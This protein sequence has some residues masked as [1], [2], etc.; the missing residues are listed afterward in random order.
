V[1]LMIF[2]QLQTTLINKYRLQDLKKGAAPNI[3]YNGGITPLM[4]AALCNDFRLLD[5]A[6][7]TMYFY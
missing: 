6:L 4:A 7:V 3:P 2:N 1:Q 5:H